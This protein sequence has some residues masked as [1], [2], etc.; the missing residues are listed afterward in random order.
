MC[1]NVST[2][3]CTATDSYSWQLLAF[4]NRQYVLTWR[5]TD[6]RILRIKILDVS[7]LDLL[8]NSRIQQEIRRKGVAFIVSLSMAASWYRLRVRGSDKRYSL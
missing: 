1:S 8:M 7:Q 2:S 4:N 6:R 3:N 5:L